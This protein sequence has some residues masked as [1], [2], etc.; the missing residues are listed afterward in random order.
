LCWFPDEESVNRSNMAT[1]FE[2]V[3]VQGNLT[4]NVATVRGKLIVAG[5]PAGFG[6]TVQDEG[7]ALTG[8]PHA[9]VNFVGAGVAVT[10]VAGVA[11]VSVPLAALLVWGADDI[12][13]EADTRFLAPGSIATAG[14]TDTRRIPIVF[15]GASSLRCLYVRHNLAA[16]N[17]ATVVYTVLVNG[18][19]TALNV[20][21]A[22][23]AVGQVF[24][25][26][27]DVAVAAGDVVSIQAVKSGA[28]GSG[29]LGV[30]AV[31]EVA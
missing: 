2:D 14:T 13:P 25:N 26:G 9:A 21:L 7:T 19:P 18:A 20:A 15:Q 1:S 24:D 12:T 3:D 22:T 11:T 31:V 5:V 8:N 30:Y 29:A 23:G 6:V 28:I 4:C 16:G 17:G 10:D 27:H